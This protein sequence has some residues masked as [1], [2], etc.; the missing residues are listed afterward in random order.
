MAVIKILECSTSSD[1]RA[2]KHI[3]GVF[4]I[5]TRQGV[6]LHYVAC[7]HGQILI[8]IAFTMVDFT[9]ENLLDLSPILLCLS[10]RY[11][12][13]SRLTVDLYFDL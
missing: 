9:A 10:K 11:S 6:A 12:G 3:R 2:I 8:N 13:F 1:Q 5:F 4:L 7:F